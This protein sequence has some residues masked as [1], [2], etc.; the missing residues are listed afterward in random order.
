MGH[1]P[2]LEQPAEFRS[3]G[4]RDRCGGAGTGASPDRMNPAFG[5]RVDQLCV[6]PPRT[7]TKPCAVETDLA[8]LMGNPEVGL[9]CNLS[10][11]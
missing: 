9:G 1:Y 3:S 8:S 5:V 6:H 2:M 11:D 7:T 10:E 4:R